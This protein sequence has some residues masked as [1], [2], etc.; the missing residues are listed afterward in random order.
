MKIVLHE[1][2][3][4]KDSNNGVTPR[5]GDGVSSPMRNTSLDNFLFRNNR[6][7]WHSLIVTCELL[8]GTKIHC[9]EIKKS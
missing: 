7:Y 9:V 8:K 1:K 2:R 3:H 4:I 5:I 6:G